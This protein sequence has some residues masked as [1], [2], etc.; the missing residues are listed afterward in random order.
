MRLVLA[1]LML[2]A[3]SRGAVSQPADCSTEPTSGPT[4]PL[5]L[6]LAGRR[7]VPPGTT[8]QAYIDVPLTPPGIACRDART[9]RRPMSCAANPAICCAG[10]ARRTCMWRCNDNLGVAATQSCDTTAVAHDRYA[11]STEWLTRIAGEDPRPCD[12]C[13]CC[14]QCCL[15][16][17]SASAAAIRRRLR[18][19]PLLCRQAQRR[20]APMARRR[21]AD[22][23]PRRLHRRY[24]RHL[25][26]DLTGEQHMRIHWNARIAQHQRGP[27]VAGV[28]R[29][30]GF[31]RG[32]ED[33]A[34]IRTVGKPY[35][36]NRQRSFPGRATVASRSARRPPAASAASPPGGPRTPPSAAHAAQ[37]S[38]S[39]SCSE[40]ARR[41]SRLSLRSAPCR[42]R[43]RRSR[44]P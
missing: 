36:R 8:G 32:V 42:T 2:V 27:G 24:P 6:D 11:E 18:T 35:R 17:A 23:S 29:I 34:D 7:N 15:A 9:A 33:A 43:V 21:P 41:A 25:P 13:S 39:H 40:T 22:N 4:L 28:E 5:A 19:P 1:I 14:C 20:S 31:R 26:H 16:D 44:T 37:S 10:Q 30:V 12:C 3:A 38:G